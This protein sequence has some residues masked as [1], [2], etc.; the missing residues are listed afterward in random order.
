MLD[1]RAGQ[2]V[3]VADKLPGG[4]GVHVVVEG[5]LLAGK[6]LRSDY[7]LRRRLFGRL[8]IAKWILG[9]IKAGLLMRV[10]AITEV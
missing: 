3:K 7:A 5:H 10:F 2:V 4:I 8:F 1:D 6:Q 9:T